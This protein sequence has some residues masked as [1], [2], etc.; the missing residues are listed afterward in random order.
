T[1]LQ[2]TLFPGHG[3]CIGFTNHHTIGDANTIIRFVRAWATVTKFGGDSQL[4]EG[5]LLP[6]YDRTSIADP[7]GL[8]SIYWE[9]MKKCRPVDS[10]PL[11]F[12]LD[13]NRVLATF[14][15]TKDDVEKLKNYVFRKLP[16]TNYVSSFT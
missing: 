15:M 2:V 3:I 6:F 7:E 10:P 8:D 5:Q 1:A 12:N 14:V 13:S 11:K 16:K 9:L 4:L